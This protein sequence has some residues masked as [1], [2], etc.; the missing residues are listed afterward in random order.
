MKENLYT[1][2]AW[3][4]IKK[5]GQY[6]VPYMIA[7][8]LMVMMFYVMN[9]LNGSDLV[10]SLNGGRTVG[11]VFGFGCCIIALF[12]FLYLFYTNSFLIRIRSRE[13]GLYSILGMNKK[14]IIRLTTIESLIVFIIVITLGIV[15]GIVIFKLVEL[16]FVKLI[17]GTPTIDFVVNS[18]VVRNAFFLYLGI[19]GVLYVHSV[20]KVSI[21][22]ALDLLKDATQGEK[23]PKGNVIFAFLGIGILGIAYWMAITI[24][25]PVKAISYF[26]VAVI[27]VIVAT[28]ILFVTGSVVLCQWMQKNKKYYY[29]PS[30]FISVSTMRFR[31]KRNGAGLASMCILMTM[32]LVM[33]SMA[34]SMYFGMQDSLNKAFHSDV[35]IDTSLTEDSR[36]NQE[37]LTRIPTYLQ[38]TITDAKDS[39]YYPCLEF[40]MG[41]VVK[42]GFVYQNSYDAMGLF[43]V[44]NLDTY[45]KIYQTNAVLG[46]GECLL[47]T[48]DKSIDSH[49][50]TFDD[51]KWNVKDVIHKQLISS[52]VNVSISKP[53]TLVVNTL[54]EVPYHKFHE[55]SPVYYLRYTCNLNKDSKQPVALDELTKVYREITDGQYRSYL[56]ISTKQEAKEA[57]LQLFG[58]IFL[59]CVLL[60]IMFLAATVLIIYYKQISEGFEDQKRFSI[61]KKVGMTN[62]EIKK[63]INSQVLIMFFSPLIFAGTHLLA[64]MPM[65]QKILVLFTVNNVT[66]FV[67]LTLTAFVIFGVFYGIVYHMTSNMYFKI[68]NS[69]ER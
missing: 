22:K 33:A 1:R 38:E 58:G 45:N 20:L 36:I 11:L 42:D 13:F 39:M 66:L 17:Q 65:V 51:V 4:G 49:T 26:F 29:Q 54:D 60:S 53:E 10:S 55:I 5:N 8:A 3:N 16:C 37:I 63:S 27:L 28:Y 41:K 69:S 52:G 24:Q 48:E 46:D 47:L 14:N 19:Y 35:V 43:Y 31:M 62:Q 67:T 21:Y 57:Y 12:S 7:G 18:E 15:S 6:Y 50:F 61:L 34:G 59:L 32:V 44:I 56:N 68:V 9:A 2:L 25:N 30:H 64:A 40:S 23:S